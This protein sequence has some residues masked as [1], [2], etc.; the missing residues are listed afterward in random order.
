MHSELVK[1]TEI[2]KILITCKFFF[3]KKKFLNFHKKIERILKV[4]AQN[5]NEIRQKRK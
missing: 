5:Y 4:I 2:F 1:K 3:N